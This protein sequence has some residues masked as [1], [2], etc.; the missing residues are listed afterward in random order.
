MLASCAAMNLAAHTAGDSRH[1]HEKH[2][3]CAVKSHR[4]PAAFSAANPA[5]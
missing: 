3:G 2:R 5:L 4:I 1:Q